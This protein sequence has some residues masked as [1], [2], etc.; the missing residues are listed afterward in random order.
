MIEKHYPHQPNAHNPAA[1]SH[2]PTVPRGALIGAAVMLA[3]VLALTAAVSFGFIARSADP[4]AERAAQN[5]AAAQVRELRFAD[6]ADGAVVVSDAQ[7]GEVVQVIAFGEGGFLRATMR[8]LIKSR[9]AK[10]I[11]PQPPFKL[12]LWENGALSLSD[13]STGREA[14]I[15]GFGPDH[16]K[17]FAQMLQRPVL[18]DPAA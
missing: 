4:Q 16:K 1:H 9:T 7:S 10:G 13:P 5:I 17:I 11:G 12:T 18:Q 6:R 14:E 15:I 2:D 8:R 3:F